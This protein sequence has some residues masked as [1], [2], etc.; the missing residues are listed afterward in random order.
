MSIYHCVYYVLYCI[1]VCCIA[2]VYPLSQC[3]AWLQVSQRGNTLP[4]G[5]SRYVV[6]KRHI[7]I[8]LLFNYS[9][10]THLLVNGIFLMH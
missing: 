10:N 6:A 5:Y 4:A 2:L 7:E 8:L 9:S 1:I 3:P